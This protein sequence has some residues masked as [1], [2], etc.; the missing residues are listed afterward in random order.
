MKVAIVLAVVCL[1]SCSSITQKKPFLCCATKVSFSC[2]QEIPEGEVV[3]K[4]G[5]YCAVSTDLFKAQSTARA[6]VQ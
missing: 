4:E 3:A 2:T 5:E 6:G 1:S